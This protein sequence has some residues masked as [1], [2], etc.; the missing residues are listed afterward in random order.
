MVGQV[1]SAGPSWFVQHRATDSLAWHLNDG[2]AIEAQS[3]TRDERFATL[4]AMA[5]AVGKAMPEA[6]DPEPATLLTLLR[7]AGFSRLFLELTAQCNESCEH[8]YADSSPARR[9]HLTE[10]DVAGVLADAKTLGFTSV[11]LTG[12]DPLIAPTFSSALRA[13]GEAQ[14]PVLEVYTNGIALHE[15]VVAQLVSARASVAFSIYSHLAEE[16]DAITRTPRSH[17][18][19]VRAIRLCRAAGVT[20]RVSL[21][22]MD[23][24]LETSEATARWLVDEIG[25]PTDALAVAHT[26]SV[27]RGL[28]PLRSGNH[29]RTAPPVDS[30][31]P[32]VGHD[33]RRDSRYKGRIAISP[34]GEILPCVFD[35]AR[36]LGHIRP[37]GLRR[38]LAAMD[39]Q[40]VEVDLFA[41]V[42]VGAGATAAHAPSVYRNSL[43][44]WQ[45]RSRASVFDQ[46]RVRRA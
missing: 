46:Q 14:F 11:Q 44:C 16:H 1:F 29:S 45:C 21:I 13:A 5:S 2:D 34:A 25:V 20:F 3:G 22:V 33:Q 8:C 40:P 26:V 35:R 7:G 42:G 6:L 28:V 4:R 37:L 23:R 32:P 10:A 12:G 38:A 39:Q 41:A 43:A 17:E 9:E 18:R 36:V 24:N 27:G 30:A 19:T 31:L 15:S